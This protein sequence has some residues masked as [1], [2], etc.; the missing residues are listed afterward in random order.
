[1]IHGVT[2]GSPFGDKI[3]D[4]D[5]DDSIAEQSELDAHS[6]TQFSDAHPGWLSGLEADRPAAGTKDRYYVATDTLVI[7]RDDGQQWNAIAQPSVPGSDEGDQLGTADERWSDVI[8]ALLSAYASSG[9][10]NPAVQLDPT[11]P[12]IAF[13]NTD[14]SGFTSKLVRDTDSRLRIEEYGSTTRDDIKA[15]GFIGVHLYAESTIRPWP[16]NSPAIQSRDD[17]DNT[18]DVGEL[19]RAATPTLDLLQHRAPL[20]S[21][22]SDTMLTASDQ[23]VSV[24]SSGGAVTVTLP[25]SVPP[26]G[27]STRIKRR[28]G[29]DVTVQPNGTEQI[30]DDGLQDS[31]TL[32][33]DG[34]YVELVSDGSDYEVRG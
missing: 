9:D 25:S 22:S 12:G 21:I 14:G 11:L 2:K 28:G 7:Y 10:A 13:G 4:G 8:A 1:M 29:N 6:G 5:V 24:D 27:W 20:T 17:A 23:E 33:V 30:Y 31:Y 34:E 3:D 26:A 32:E 19:R 15:A 18:V 16:G